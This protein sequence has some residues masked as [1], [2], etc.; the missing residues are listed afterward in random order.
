MN[1]DIIES[2]LT[3]VRLQT[4]SAAADAMFISQSTLSHRLQMLEQELNVQLFERQRGFKQMLLTE[5]GRQFIP[6]A[7]QWLELDRA[8]HQTMSSPK[9]GRIVIASM[10]SVNR[11]LLPP[12]IEP[13]K[14]RHPE[15]QMEFVSYHSQEIYSRLSSRQIDVGFAFHPMHNELTAAPVFDEP[16]YMICPVSGY[17][18]EGRIHPGSLRKRDEVFF[19]W[20]TQTELWNNEWWDELEDPYVKVDSTALMKTFLTEPQHWA[21]CPASVATFLRDQ[22]Q[23]ELHPFTVAPPNR[24]CYLLQRKASGSFLP[25]S[26]EILLQEFYGLL[27][28]HPW[29]YREF[30]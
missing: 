11:Y 23:V 26:M 29:H 6:F 21:I 19:A 2:F 20:N 9:L 16:M 3:I 7:E 12:I 1:K 17:Y 30:H 8:I 28:D 15:I 13:I 10:D 22:G 24:V 4:I 5:S 14:R 25:K 27:A 18:P